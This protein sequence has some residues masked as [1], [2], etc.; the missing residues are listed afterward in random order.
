MP[1][2]SIARVPA[3]VSD[4]Q[5]AALPLAGASAWAGLVQTA[6]VAPG[7]K[8]LVHAAAGGVGSLAVQIARERGAHVVAT[9]SSR[10]ADF[11]RSLGAQQVVA[12]DRARFEDEVR[13]VDVVFDIMGGDVHKRS[14]KVLKRGGVMAMLASAPIVDEGA[15][16]GVEVK[17]ARVAP[18]PK[19]LEQL[20]ALAAAGK[21]TIEVEH[22]LPLKEF[23]KAQE[24]SATGHA[25]G[26]TVLLMR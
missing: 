4:T 19:V 18:D 21:L 13:D 15:A 12:Y 23:A 14:Y 16:Y 1:L 17:M 25:R 8:V 7:M 9:C 11:V 22:T 5:A 2:S 26:K 20:V 24:I 3:S 10:N 6:N